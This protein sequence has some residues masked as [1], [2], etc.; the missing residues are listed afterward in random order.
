MIE[1]GS[2]APF[3]SVFE[4][5]NPF[6]CPYVPI[7]AP[8]KPELAKRLDKTAPAGSGARVCSGA[9]LTVSEGCDSIQGG[10][11]PRGPGLG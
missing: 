6:F 11:S 4:S 8:M 2:T 10:A 7:H 1:P 3:G 9:A 5:E